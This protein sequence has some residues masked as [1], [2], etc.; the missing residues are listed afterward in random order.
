MNHQ[1][2]F[3]KL[4]QDYTQR[5][6]QAKRI[7]D[8]FVSEGE[9]IYND[10][11]ALRTL[12]DPRINIDALAQPFIKNGYKQGGDYHF[13]NKKLYAKHFE[14]KSDSSAPLVFI[15]QLNMADVSDFVRDTLES[16]IEQIPYEIISEPERLLLAQRPWLLPSY[17]I[18]KQL[19]QESEYAAWIYVH[20]YRANHFTISVNRLQKYDTLEKVNQ[21]LK[22][23]NFVLNDAG[24]E[25]KG[26]ADDL[27]EQSST[28]AEKIRLNFKEGVYEVPSCYY[29][30]ARRYHD[31][32]SRLYKG[33]VAASADKIFE[34]TN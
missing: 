8:L 25:I 28:M 7:Y 6:P 32:N 16:C 23:H 9:T 13:P 20:G 26:T 18:Y 14:H 34:S 2:I 27:L 22:D 30:F 24:G 33:F 12:S 31:K 29:E 15:S 10:H 1:M 5:N 11:I 21:F 3:D 19:M 4:W 17:E